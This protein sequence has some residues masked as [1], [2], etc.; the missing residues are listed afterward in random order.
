MKELMRGDEEIRNRIREM[1]EKN[2]G[3]EKLRG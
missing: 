3:M 2:C 1:V